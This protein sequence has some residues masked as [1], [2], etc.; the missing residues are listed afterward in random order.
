MKVAL[1]IGVQEMVRSDLGGSGVMFSIDTESG[2]DKVVCHRCRP[3]GWAKTSSRARSIQ[4]DSLHG[5]QAAFSE[6]LL[7]PI[8]EKVRGEKSIKM[9]YAT[10]EHPT[11]NVPT[12]KAERAA[13]VSATAKS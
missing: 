9:I 4:T 10:G 5:L 13:F 12:S 3:G 2:F 7:V 6:P 8:V 11:R 1:S